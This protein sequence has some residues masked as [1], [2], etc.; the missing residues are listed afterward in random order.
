MVFYIKKIRR[1]KNPLVDILANKIYAW[2]IDFVQL[3]ANDSFAIYFEE[4]YVDNKCVGIGKVFAA[5]FTHKGKTINA[6]R[7]KEDEKFVDYFDSSGNNLRSAFLMSPVDFA[8]VSSGFGHRKHPISGKWKKHNGVD[9]AAKTGTPVMTTAN[10]T[11]TFCG[12]KGGYG[13]CL[14]VNIMINIQLF[15]HLSKYKKGIS[16]GLMSHKEM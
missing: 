5:S 8:R 9:Y 15:I 11:I 1:R 16:R 3:Q 2:S 4:K 13:K 6:F 7:F 10:G 14:I 12:W